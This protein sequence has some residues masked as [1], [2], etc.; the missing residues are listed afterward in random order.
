MAQRSDMLQ[1]LTEHGRPN[2]HDLM[3]PQVLPFI[4]GYKF[5]TRPV[6]NGVVVIRNIPYETTQAEVIAVLGKSSKILNDRQEPVHIIMDRVT[7][8]TQD[9]YCEFSS[10]DAAI[11]IVNRFKKGPE[12]GRIARLGNR[13]IEVELSSQ[14]KLMATL[15]PSSKYSVNWERGQP[16]IKRNPEYPWES[17]KGFIT[18]EEMVMLA[19]HVENPQRSLY[20]RICPERPYE[21]MISTLRK[22]PWYMADDITLKQRNSVYETCMKMIG[23]LAGKVKQEKSSEIKRL[24]PQLFDR[25]VASAMLCHGFSVVQKHNIATLAGLSETKCREFNQPRFPDSW[26]YQW[27]LVP[28]ANMPIDVLE[29]YIAVIRTETNRIVQGL[30]ISQRMALQGMMKDLDGYWGFFW[31]DANF[32]TGRVWDNM[33]LAE[34]SRLEWRA[35]ERII[36]RA[37]Q[38]GNIPP[39]YTSGSY[40]INPAATAGHAR[41]TYRGY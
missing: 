11:E 33:S 18:E 28:K 41:L 5:A 23:V 22:I 26:R 10:Q 32:P 39:S 37:I 4:E 24:T 7:S 17:F 15:F 38:G 12:N 21:C 13:V 27:T 40:R 8:K 6:E 2:L 31:A 29:W 14:K 3:S 16:D 19:K 35:I 36:T 25:L 34:C 1:T 20:A 9:V 30:D